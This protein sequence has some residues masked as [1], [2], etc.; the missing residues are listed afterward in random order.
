MA[1][2][3]EKAVRYTI[4]LGGV[5]LVVFA[6]F[7]FVNRPQETVRVGKQT[8]SEDRSL[9]QTVL[10]TAPQQGVE[11][12][13]VLLV[14]FGDFQCPFCQQVAPILDDIMTKYNDTVRRVWVHIPNTEIHDQANSAA[15]ASQ[16][17][18]QQGK[19]WEFHDGLFEQQENLSSLLYLQLA[20]DL[21]LDQELFETC[22]TDETVA[23]LV[24]TH[25]Q[26]A[27]R[28]GVDATPYI[29]VNNTVISG[30]FTFEQVDQLIQQ[31]FSL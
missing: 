1:T 28:S 8:T 12:G 14:E 17:A 11:D 5:L 15:I 24:R 20:N 9:I 16:C 3:E 18:H 6:I 7:L 31:Q 29:S 27:R 25:S 19:F 10:D 26:F 30:V 22:L 13:A 21:Q 2:N 23:D 4:Y